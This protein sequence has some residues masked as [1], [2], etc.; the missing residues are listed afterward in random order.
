[1]T[2]A[3]N[4]RREFAATLEAADQRMTANEERLA[5]SEERMATVQKQLDT[6]Q[7]ALQMLLQTQ[8]QQQQAMPQQATPQQ[9]APQQAAPQQAAPQQAAPQQAAPQ[10]A[11]EQAAPQRRAVDP[12]RIDDGTNDP[13]SSDDDDDDDASWTSSRAQVAHSAAALQR[14]MDIL[15]E[16]PRDLDPRGGALLASYYSREALRIFGNEPFPNAKVQYINEQGRQTRALH[17]VANHPDLTELQQLILVRYVIA[18]QWAVQQAIADTGAKGGELLRKAVEG[19]TEEMEDK[20]GPY[21]DLLRSAVKTNKMHEQL[22]GGGGKSRGSRGG[23]NKKGESSKQ[24]EGKPDGKG[25][26]AKKNDK[27]DAK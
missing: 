6:I 27:P 4:V 11:P 19:L 12:A 13:S 7:Q 26:G 18:Q 1:M 17:H 3:A 22:S 10:A 14:A 16:S 23:N 9:A 24:G 8:Q 5:A 25:D 15:H 21:K 2:T 20:T